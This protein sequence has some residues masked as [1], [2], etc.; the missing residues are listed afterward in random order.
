ML[1]WASPSPVTS[2]ALK[3]LGVSTPKGS[4]SVFCCSKKSWDI[5]NWEHENPWIQWVW[6]FT[7]GFLW[8]P[9]RCVKPMA[10]PQARIVAV[11][12][13]TSAA[14]RKWSIC[15]SSKHQGHSCRGTKKIHS[16]SFPK[17]W[18][19]MIQ[20]DSAI[21][22][23]KNCDWSKWIWFQH[24]DFFVRQVAGPHQ[25]FATAPCSSCKP[26]TLQF[27]QLPQ[28]YFQPSWCWATLGGR[29][30]PRIDWWTWLHLTRQNHLIHQSWLQD[31]SSVLNTFKYIICF[32]EKWFP[33]IYTQ[34]LQVSRCQKR[35]AIQSSNLRKSRTWGFC[36]VGVQ[37]QYG[38]VTISHNEVII[39]DLSNKWIVNMDDGF[40]TIQLDEVN[41]IR[42][43]LDWSSQLLIKTSQKD[44]EP[45][46]VGFVSQLAN[47]FPSA[48]LNRP[49]N[50]INLTPLHFAHHLR[51]LGENYIS[52][53]KCVAIR[54]RPSTLFFCIL[55]SRFRLCSK[56]W[57]QNCRQSG[58]GQCHDASNGCSA[59]GAYLKKIDRFCDFPIRCAWVK[60][61]ARYP[62]YPMHK[63]PCSNY[64][65]GNMRNFLVQPLILENLQRRQPSA[66]TLTSLGMIA[67]NIPLDGWDEWPWIFQYRHVTMSWKDYLLKRCWELC[68]LTKE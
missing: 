62:M 6:L 46:A 54:F 23:C 64:S 48:L 12:A 63:Y 2:C 9:N 14:R 27:Q 52:L 51:D 29:L 47:H 35:S 45:H 41:F 44:R 16:E 40:N 10:F 37:Q 34:L 58:L 28:N 17:I 18:F 33:I 66:E 15:K 36:V 5:S 1:F 7:M 20:L 57:W 43:L 25:S 55:S 21:K 8:F 4:S 31:T 42:R 65:N 59:G 32:P 26:P 50:D 30:S 56:R 22:N 13:A 60:Q 49:A 38:L 67:G 39:D 3:E 11:K 68:V 24:L 19:N 61:W 53:S